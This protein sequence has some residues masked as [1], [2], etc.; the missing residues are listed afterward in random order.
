[1]VS[2]DVFY[3]ERGLEDEWRSAGARA[4]EMEAAALFA[5]YARR[6]AGANSNRDLVR[7][8]H[9]YADKL[10][11]DAFRFDQQA[12]ERHI[13]STSRAARAGVVA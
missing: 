9:E 13:L 1:M 11:S 6:L 2:S 8:L 3:D 12:V 4:V 5:L 10:E 7:S